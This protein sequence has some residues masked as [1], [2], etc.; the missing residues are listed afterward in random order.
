MELL[1]LHLQLS[2]LLLF[3]FSRISFSCTAKETNSGAHEG[4]NFYQ[5]DTMNVQ[6]PRASAYKRLTH[7]VVTL[8]PYPL[9]QVAAVL[10]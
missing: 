9:K 1:N 5:K 3:L 4:S 6:E 7:T 8:L 2:P 10:V